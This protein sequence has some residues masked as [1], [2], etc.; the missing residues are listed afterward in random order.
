VGGGWLGGSGGW[1]GGGGGGGRGAFGWGLRGAAG[2]W[3]RRAGPAGPARAAASSGVGWEGQGGEGAAGWGGEGGGGRRGVAPSGRGRADGAAA[4]A[5]MTS[6]QRAAAPPTPGPPTH[7][8]AGSNAMR[9]SSSE[10]LW[11]SGALGRAGPRGPRGWMNPAPQSRGAAVLAKTWSTA[12]ISAAARGAA[13]AVACGGS[14]AGAPFGEKGPIRGVAGARCER[15][16]SREAWEW[17]RRPRGGRAWD[18]RARA[19][20]R[21]AAAP[22][23][24]PSAWRARRARGRV[25]R[26]WGAVRRV[27]AL[28][29]RRGLAARPPGP[30]AACPRARGRNLWGW[31]GMRAAR[32]QASPAKTTPDSAASSESQQ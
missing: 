2:G 17:P 22:P 28:L 27:R 6:S 12:E 24:T 23:A 18:I 26:R 19:R 29:R 31:G 8:P 16:V 4:P 11:A 10:K 3:E 7:P 20:A 32:P 5:T 15:G 30:A 13:R 21:A 25:A 1:R 14:L 9:T